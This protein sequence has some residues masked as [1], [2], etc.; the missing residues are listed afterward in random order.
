MSV[1]LDPDVGGFVVVRCAASF[2]CLP[3]GVEA[4]AVP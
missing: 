3:A 1:D 4:L 2:R